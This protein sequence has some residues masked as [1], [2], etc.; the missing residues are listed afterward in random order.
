[1]AK[2]YFPLVLGL[3]LGVALCISTSE[4]NAQSPPRP[5]FP[6]PEFT[7]FPPLHSGL[8]AFHPATKWRGL[9]FGPTDNTATGIQALYSATG[10]GSNTADGWRALYSTT[11]SYSNVGV[12]YEALA[13][14]ITGSYNTAVGSLAM[15]ETSTSQNTAVGFSAMGSNQT[16]STNT[17][18]G[19]MAINSNSSGSNLTAVGANALSAGNESNSVAVGI[20]ALYNSNSSGYNTAVGANAIGGGSYANTGGF[21]TVIG[22]SGLA[23]NSSGQY[24]V[25]GGS[26]TMYVNTTGSYNSATGAG[27]LY[28]NT[29]GNENVGM[30]E[31]ALFSNT[32]GSNN[33]ALGYSA[34]TGSGALSNAM[35]L[36]ANSTVNSSNQVVIGSSSVTSIGGYANWSNFSDGRYKKN[37]Q[38]NVPG[39]AFIKKLTPITYTLDI[40]GIETKLHENIKSPAD[41]NLA[42]S[43]NYLSDPVVQQSIQEK[44]SVTYTGFVAQDVEK[45][46]ESVGFAFS[47]IDKPKDVNQSFYGLR[48]GDFVVPLVKAVQE[49]S[50]ANDRKDSTIS[51]IQGQLDS[52]QIQINELRSLLLARNSSVL[53]GASLDQN[54]PNPSSNSTTIGYSLPQG[55][56]SAKMQVTDIS[57]RVLQILSLSGAGRNAVTIDTSGLASGTYTYSLLINGQLAGTRKMIAV[58]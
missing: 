12:G 39:L 43:A 11:V 50:A 29:S 57:G 58:R 2:N 27:A 16:G 40:N 55:V 22:S 9:S 34:N 15:V 28:N 26:Y 13:D 47:G 6:A 21:N 25:S 30:G 32:T 1:M 44:S 52:M 38:Q 48:Y 18:M 4:L 5:N 36:G 23:A 31:L 53:S 46:A 19:Y 10:G 14:D 49:L 45:A 20:N 8:Q 42:V 24:N 17:A 33:T 35:A 37:I 41:K 54:V 3:A 51:T 7:S 56:S